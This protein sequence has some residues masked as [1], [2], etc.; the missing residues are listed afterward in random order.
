MACGR[1]VERISER[2]APRHKANIKR[3][4][5]T[6]DNVRVCLPTKSFGYSYLTMV[7]SVIHGHLATMSEYPH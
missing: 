4:V 6:S 5:I 2:C 7:C 3:T 1:C